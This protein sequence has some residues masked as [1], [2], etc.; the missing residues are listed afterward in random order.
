LLV[1]LCYSPCRTISV[2]LASALVLP[3]VHSCP[4][5]TPQP[6]LWCS[7]GISQLTM[8]ITAVRRC[9]QP[10]AAEFSLCRCSAY[11]KFALYRNFP[12]EAAEASINIS[13][14]AAT[15]IL[16]ST[17]VWISRAG[18]LLALAVFTTCSFC[19]GF[20]CNIHIL[21]NVAARCFGRLWRTLLRVKSGPLNFLISSKLFL[22][23]NV[24]LRSIFLRSR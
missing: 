2:G 24:D 4:I 10:L 23:F 18:Q 7:T 15:C 22:S 1:W 5:C 13:L 20:N 8:R 16:P 12:T 21:V 14:R 9:T 6:S 19:F 3:V 11:P 17:S